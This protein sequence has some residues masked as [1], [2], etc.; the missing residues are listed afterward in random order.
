[1]LLGGTFGLGVRGQLDL[2]FLFTGTSILVG[3]DR[4]FPSNCGDGC[5]FWEASGSVVAS[6]GQAV[7]FGAGTAFQKFDRP[8][9]LVTT[10]DWLVNF[11]VGL[12]LPGTSFLTPFVEARFEAFSETTNQIVFS[13]GAMLG[14]TAARRGG[15][16]FRR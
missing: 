5:S 9:D 7:Y 6:G 13:L 4:Y 10:E 11:L 12:N 1:E 8:D 16:G 14:P 15:G 3:Y 2:G